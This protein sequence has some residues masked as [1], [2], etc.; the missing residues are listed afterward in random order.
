MKIKSRKKLVKELTR[1]RALNLMLRKA[2]AD[3]ADTITSLASEL[4]ITNRSISHAESALREK[5]IERDTLVKFHA[6]T[7]SQIYRA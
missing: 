5:E 7:V 1:L 2:N 3:K 6:D 4:E